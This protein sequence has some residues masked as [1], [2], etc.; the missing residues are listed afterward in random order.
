MSNDNSRLMFVYDGSSEVQESAHLEN[1]SILRAGRTV[2]QKP[3]PG[4]IKWGD[5]TNRR[6]PPHTSS[7]RGTSPVNIPDREEP[8]V[9]G[10]CGESGDS[11]LLSGEP[12]A[13]SFPF[14]SFAATTL[15]LAKVSRKR[16]TWPV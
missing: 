13:P 9:I 4:Y 15:R 12:R 10:R 2:P 14:M 11:G 8:C 16:G 5:A 1:R 7:T 3:L 6:C